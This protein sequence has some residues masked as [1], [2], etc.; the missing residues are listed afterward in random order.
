VNDERILRRLVDCAGISVM[1][2]DRNGIVS[3]AGGATGMLGGFQPD[4]LVGNNML[5]HIDTTWNPIALDS[6]GAAL[7]GSGLQRPMLF[8]LLRKDGTSF[9]A[10]VQANS[11]WDD[12]DID[13]MVVYIR[14]N[15]ERVLLDEVVE[16]VASGADVDDTLAVI[17]QVMGAETLE[18]HGVVFVEPDRGRFVRTVT[19][20][21]I[22]AEL[23]T[24]Y[25][26]P[27]TPWNVA[28]TNSVPAW[29][30]V[31]DLPANTRA[32]AERAGYRWCWAWP[33]VHSGVVTGC[34]VLWR[35]ADEPPDHTCTMV[36]DNLSRL[37]GL[38]LDQAQHQE[39]LEHAALHDPLTGLPNRARFFDH[40]HTIVSRGPGPIVGVL[41]VDLDT[42][43]PVNDRL[44][45]AAGDRVL[46][47][48]GRRLSAAVRD[49][50]LVA[51]LGGDEF[52]IACHGVSDAGVLEAIA[53]RVTAAIAEPMTI[54][55]ERVQVGASVGIASCEPG[56]LSADQL[57]EAA[58]AA[59]YQAKQS[60]RGGWTSSASGVQQ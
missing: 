46:K 58:D 5:D 41:Y 2:V 25:G 31:A 34:L 19:P 12:P 33:V 26:G 7:T 13:G 57:V 48:A 29:S 10:E 39:R 27:A 32:A 17:A 36:L 4:E 3:W 14:R 11:Q 59:L 8:R 28:L 15:D 42:F 54:G 47:T 51:R 23:R 40:V 18:G 60:G 44:G 55:P 38:V 9:V 37:T 6:V 20:V 43:K 1:V 56:A 16:K 49:R 53:A 35:T 45:H 24:D 50:D 30:P 22:A 21:D 52:A